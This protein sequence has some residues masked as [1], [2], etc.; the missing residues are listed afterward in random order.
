VTDVVGG[1]L[2]GIMAPAGRDANLKKLEAASAD[3]F[4]DAFKGG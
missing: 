3:R 1:N 2:F 4:D